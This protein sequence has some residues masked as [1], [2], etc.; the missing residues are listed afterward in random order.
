M[1][2]V[3]KDNKRYQSKKKYDHVREGPRFSFKAFHTL[4][5]AYKGKLYTTSSI[6]DILLKEMIV[7]KTKDERILGILEYDHLDML[8]KWYVLCEC[9]WIKLYE[10]EQKAR[11]A[12]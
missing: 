10:T 7:N 11:Q 5:I 2:K 6:P 1:Q 9:K 3:N 8:Q 4:W 12:L